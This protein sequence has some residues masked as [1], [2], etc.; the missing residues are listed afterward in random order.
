MLRAMRALVG[1][2]SSRTLLKTAVR[3]GI[4]R[5]TAAELSFGAGFLGSRN[6]RRYPLSTIAGVEL[7][8]QIAGRAVALIVQLVAEPPLRFDGVSPVAARRL[9][10]LLAALRGIRS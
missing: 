8:E 3:G 7:E 4:L 9:R 6:L 2:G 5:L 10:E 1:V